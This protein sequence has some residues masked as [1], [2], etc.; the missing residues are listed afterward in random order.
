MRRRLILAAALAAPAAAY[1]AAQSSALTHV[2]GGMW[3]I[4]GA[5]GI[6]AP[7]RQCVTDVLAL[8]QFE[9]RA[10]H[11]TRSVLKDGPSSTR[12]DYKCGTAG[13]GQSDVEVLTPRSLRIR[14]QGISDQ[15]PF[16]YVLQARRVGECTKS[17]SSS[18]H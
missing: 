11:C 2:M 8:A 12:I 13:F 17:A 10:Q 4:S 7:V 5:P 18:R 16:A 9:H 1:G 3:E 15:L 6:S 14:T